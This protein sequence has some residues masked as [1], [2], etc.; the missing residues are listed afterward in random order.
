MSLLFPRSFLKHDVLTYALRA[1][2]A[3]P[4]YAAY[5][6]A[7]ITNRAPLFASPCIYCKKSHR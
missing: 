4:L 5:S 1:L 7:A 6:A 2:A 3:R